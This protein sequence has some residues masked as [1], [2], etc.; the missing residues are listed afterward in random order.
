MWNGSQGF[1]QTELPD[2]LLQYNPAE[3]TVRILI[4]CLVNSFVFLSIVFCVRVV[5]Y[6]VCDLAWSEWW[7]SVCATW[8]SSEMF[9]SRM[10]HFWLAIDLKHPSVEAV[11]Q[12]SYLV[13]KMKALKRWC[14]HRRTKF[15]EGILG[16]FGFLFV[17]DWFLVLVCL[18]I[19][20]SV[21]R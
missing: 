2:E 19:P 6:V 18:S 3:M 21:I 5:E 11:A 17:W 13:T 4:H 15:I 16:G 7:F 10:V 8:A 9:Y 1:T 14:D 12:G 20:V